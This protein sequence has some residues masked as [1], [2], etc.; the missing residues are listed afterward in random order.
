[1]GWTITAQD[2]PT[3]QIGL[4]YQGAVS[5]ATR[6]EHRLTVGA[7]AVV[8]IVLN[9]NNFDPVLQIEHNGQIWL[10]VDDVGEST[11]AA[12]SDYRI[13]EAG[14]YILVVYAFADRPYTGSY[15]LL[16]AQGNA[17]TPNQTICPMALP[18]PF[19][20]ESVAQVRED[21]TARQLYQDP[22]LSSAKVG[23]IAPGDTV[24]LYEGPECEEGAL[25]WWVQNGDTSGWVMESNYG[26]YWL[27]PTDPLANPVLLMN[28]IGRSNNQAVSNGEFQVE[29]YCRQEGYGGTGQNNDDWFCT[30]NGQRAYTLVQ[31]DF[32]QICR[33][34]YNRNDAFA[35]QNGNNPTP[36]Y[37]WLCYAPG[38]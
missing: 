17:D 1:M 13:P 14:D 15:T 37:R 3:L 28:G 10:I 9:S 31:A 21:G 33:D 22:S 27:V 20:F 29:Y 38:G 26:D 7:D 2:M 4:P 36:A 34:T 35:L 6:T 18:T 25:W 32:D 16:V 23:R 8:T 24:T 30:N 19:D 11:N 5:D 12:V